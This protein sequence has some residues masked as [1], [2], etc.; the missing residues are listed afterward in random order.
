MDVICPV[1]NRLPGLCQE[2]INGD[3]LIV[4]MR[5]EDPAGEWRVSEDD[6]RLM[7]QREP[8][9]VGTGPYYRMYREGAIKGE[10]DGVNFSIQKPRDGNLNR[11]FPAGWRPD[12]RQYGAGDLP[13]SEPESKAIA[14]FLLAHPNISGMQCYH[15][16]GGLHSTPISCRTR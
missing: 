2:D 5:I 12:Y 13:L 8:G 15:T 6:P 7:V 4:E 9:E 16:H 14:D 3:G 10:W 1:K 11:N